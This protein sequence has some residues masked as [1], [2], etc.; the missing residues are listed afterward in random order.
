MAIYSL[1]HSAIGKQ[2]HAAGTAGAHVRY[3]TRKQA[4][5]E[6]IA[7]LIPANRNEARAW[8]EKHEAESRKNARVC[9]KLIVALPIELDAAQ[10]LALARDFA[11]KL[12]EGRVPYYGAIH[13][14]GKDASN[15]HLHLIVVDRDPETGKR[16][17]LTSEKG[18]TERFRG[19]WEQVC[20][21]HL[22]SAGIDTRIDRRTLEAQGIERAPQIHV[23]A[24]GQH[25]ND[26]VRR[27]E[28]QAREVGIA[29]GKKTRQVDYPAIDQGRTRKEFNDQLIDANLLKAK[30]S[31]DF[32]TRKRAEVELRLR[33]M[34]KLDD[35]RFAE[36]RRALTRR[37]REARALAWQQ[38][39]AARKAL[40]EDRDTKAARVRDTIKEQ[41]A[42][43]WAEY[44][45]WKTQAWHKLAQDKRDQVA[46]VR[47]AHAC[48][49][50]MKRGVHFQ[51]G[52]LRPVFGQAAA[53]PS[54]AAFALKR[55]EA[56]RRKA[57]SDRQSQTL[58]ERL[59]Q[60]LSQSRAAMAAEKQ[61]YQ[62]QR[63]EFQRSQREQ[64]RELFRQQIEAREVR[65][66]FRKKQEAVIGQVE[67]AMRKTDVGWPREQPARAV[68]GLQA[69]NSNKAD[70]VA[71][72]FEAAGRKADPG[73]A[74]APPAR[75]VFG[76]AAGDS[77]SRPKHSTP[78]LGRG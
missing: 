51:P 34:K 19:L 71:S 68:F 62:D 8:M 46:R 74:S 41:F 33:T 78:T 54:E 44:A 6:I 1:N 27:P 61:R 70:Q 13:A 24:E 69:A 38:H 76:R 52:M 35:Q 17:L 60:T 77:S 56:A 7:N 31:P 25:M 75:A 53:K 43:A 16:H 32:G 73:W 63:A 2:T 14:A 28:S 22:A 23:G 21:E 59:G 18:S 65:D 40:Q 15:P 50:Q 48:I 5:P 49:A 42:P 66:A 72:H 45:D 58:K 20:N 4:V 10:R 47:H 67:G 12:T 11:A 26:N 30:L 55:E 36:A 9:D 37:D 29:A 3:V 39:Q 64:W 57:I